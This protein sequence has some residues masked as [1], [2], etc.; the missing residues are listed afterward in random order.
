MVSLSGMIC[1]ITCDT[2]TLPYNTPFNLYI[3]NTG[4]VFF[5]YQVNREVALRTLEVD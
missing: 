5:L 4:R 3:E 1:F 2:C